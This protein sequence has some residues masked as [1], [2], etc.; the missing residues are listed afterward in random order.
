M[1]EGDRVFGD[2]ETVRSLTSAF[3]HEDKSLLLEDNVEFDLFCISFLKCMGRF[4]NFEEWWGQSSTFG[5]T[6]YSVSS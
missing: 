5:K 2:F 4:I 3:R 1:C 6:E